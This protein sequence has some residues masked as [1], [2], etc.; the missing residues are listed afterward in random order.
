M[1]VEFNLIIGIVIVTLIILLLIAG[2][3]LSFFMIS[4]EKSR[5]EAALSQARL[6]YE[7]ELRLVENELSEQL[8]Q[9]FSRELHDN[10]GHMLTCLRL[11]LENRK[12]DNEAL[13]DEL[14]TADR[15]LDETTEQ[16]RLLSR[17]LN[18]D[19]IARNGL[20]QS[21]SLEIE[22]YRRLKKFDLDWQH[23]YGKKDMDSNQ[24]LMVF[25]IF[26][27]ILNNAAKHSKARKL[28]VHIYSEP[29]F[30]LKI[31]DDGVGFDS[32]SVLQS[33]N[34]SGLSNILK[35]AEMAGLQCQINST[36]GEGTTF[37]FTTKAKTHEQ[38]LR[39]KIDYTGR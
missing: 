1:D 29:A 11:E 31:S 19:Y 33:H 27:E 4:K 37:L 2:I 23:Q 8:M 25:R 10:V 15:Y 13:F 3:T 7:K 20:I 38:H 9:Q 17:S 21:M 35:R 5:K 14:E 39:Q 34:S 24:E 6:S 32:K 28:N 30:T 36:E 22:R 16:L 26:Q 18:T 12:L